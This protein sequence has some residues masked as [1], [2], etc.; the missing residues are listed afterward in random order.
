[1][2]LFLKHIWRTVR[3]TP[4]QPILILLT[5][6]LATAVSVTAFRSRDLFAEHAYA[7]AY[8]NA[9]LGDVTVSLRGDSA[10]RMLFLE[11]AEAALGNGGEVLG[12][13]A[14]TAFT[15]QEGK[16]RPISVSAV[17]LQAADR[18]FSFTY[19][20]YGHFTTQNAEQSVILSA[21]AAEQLG[22]GVGDS[23]T[24]RVLD[25]EQAYTVQAI[26]RENGLLNGR[27]V[28][29]PIES[30]T[31]L[32]A[33]R[34]PAIASLGDSFKPYNRLLIRVG[35]GDSIDAVC[36]RLSAH[37]AFHS[38][39]IER[40]V[41]D[42]RMEYTLL[43][44]TVSISLLAL[45]IVVL[46]GILIA[47]SLGLLHA[48]RSME[49]AL[50][51][52][53]GASR[54]NLSLLSLVESWIYAVTGGALG[55]ALAAPM[56]DFVA[57]LF[58][59]QLQKV[60]VDVSG[61]VF[62]LLLSVGLMTLCTVI[63]L[64]RQRAVTL[65][66][67]LQ[68]ENHEQSLATEPKARTVITS[69]L[70]TC[71]FI[72]LTLLIP[73]NYC[74]LTGVAAILALV[75]HLYLITPI[76]LRFAAS[77][78]ERVSE[79]GDRPHPNLLLA[80]KNIRNHA[81]VR[82]TGRLL[83][84]TLTLLLVVTLCTSVVGEQ[85]SLLRG[86]ITGDLLVSG[87]PRD[88]AEHLRE[89]VAVEGVATL[90]F[91]AEA[92]IG[93]GYTAFAMLVSGDVTACVDP[94]ILPSTLPEGTQVAMSLGVAE[95][96]N[97]KV[98]D[99][100]TITLRGVPYA[101]TVCEVIHMSANFVF[102]DPD[103]ID[104]SQ[105]MICV[106]WN[107][108]ADPTERASLI[109]DMESAGAIAVEKESVMQT[110]HESLGGFLRLL[111]WALLAATVPIT[112]GGINVLTAQ[113]RARRREKRLLC[114]SGMRKGSILIMRAV[115]LTTVCVF[116]VLFSAVYGGVACLLIN[117]CVKSFGFLLF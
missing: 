15:S 106:K 38:A 84:V 76:L 105:A 45:L 90:D 74:Y 73:V 3:R 60:Y 1:M 34:A 22:V 51:C 86:S 75:W 29:I 27:D 24:L 26:A 114:A 69:A 31:R 98:G 25:V 111:H 30:V 97:A 70:V 17:D 47:T 18:Y 81:A 109:A 61:I 95:L 55:I 104:S 72:A 103:A 21:S 11:D 6:I 56:L 5:V 100:V 65:A 58:E 12:E 99:T 102:L 8:A 53:A 116:A 82:H 19:I 9:E 85:L 94:A 54:A 63:Q 66:V 107:S 40:T 39:L 110:I 28:L 41:T 89:N 33:A 42:S 93:E 44:Q 52:S 83:A 117:E 62:G 20:A 23:L 50:F 37:E 10:V 36:N 7:T 13:Y 101:L 4:I 88:E 77:M 108:D 64:A 91:V 48:Q 43:V 78:L 35:E 14:L 49:Y 79:R 113:Y 80:F 2:R 112:I 46:S 96:L 32:L 59:W 68:E 57:T 71:L 115:E 87:L 92:E 67:W 16:Y